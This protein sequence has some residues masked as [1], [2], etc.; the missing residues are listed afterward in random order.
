MSIH[1]FIIL[2]STYIHYVAITYH[3][4][5]QLGRRKVYTEA[6]THSLWCHA[7]DPAGNLL[8]ENGSFTVINAGL[9]TVSQAGV[10]G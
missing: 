5:R 8:E 3:T 2:Q 6:P 1:R 9:R 10:P 7:W 4:V